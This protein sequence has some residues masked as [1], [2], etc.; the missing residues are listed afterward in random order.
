MQ[1][2]LGYELVYQCPQPT[3]M[4]I[5]LRVT[6]A[7]QP[8]LLQPDFMQVE[9]FVPM[10]TYYDV[11]GNQCS[12]LVAPPGQLRLWADAIIQDSGEPEP[13]CWDAIQ[14]PVEALPQETLVYLVASRYCET[15]EFTTLAWQLFGHT[16]P[17]WARVQAICD[18]VHEQIEFGYAHAS[19]TK[20]AGQTWRERRGVCRDFAHLAITFCRCLNIPARYCTAYLGDIGVPPVAAP[21]DFAA[22]ME[23]YLGNRWHSFDPRNNQRRIGRVLIA[24][25]RDAADVAITTT[26]GPHTLEVFRVWTDEVA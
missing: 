13:A 9:P 20:T 15:D 16:Q 14:H 26:Y 17:G 21:M 19:V 7:R 8:D 5:N 23:V 10:E 24:R 18:Y 2:R 11:F 1:I 25:G 4:I 22:S 3:P 6:A 12:R